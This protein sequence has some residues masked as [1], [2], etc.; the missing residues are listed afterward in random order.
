MSKL[1]EIIGLILAIIALA[2]HCGWAER[3]SA[4]RKKNLTSEMLLLSTINNGGKIHEFYMGWVIN[5]LKMLVRYNMIKRYI[6]DR[7][8]VIRNGFKSINSPW[9]LFLFLISICLFIIYELFYFS[10][11]VISEL[12]LFFSKDVKS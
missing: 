2:K 12:F 7:Y 9:S 8:N 6:I 5:R 4:W 10:V 1:T 11:C 3:L